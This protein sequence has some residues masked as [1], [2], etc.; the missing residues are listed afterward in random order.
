[1]K[2]ALFLPLI[3]KLSKVYFSN[4]LNKEIEYKKIFFYTLKDLG[5]VYIKFLQ[6]ICLA[7]DFMSDWAGPLE[8][9]VFNKVPTEDMNILDYVK[10][11]DSFSSIDEIP[12]ACGS[13]AQ[14]Y[15]AQLTTGEVV[16]IKVLRPSIRKNLYSDLNKLSRMVKI[17]SKFLPNTIFDY[18]GAF[19]EF[20]RNCLLEVN[21]E[22]EIANMKYFAKLYNNHSYIEIPRVYDKFSSIDIIVQEYI[23]GPTLADVLYDMKVGDTP[24]SLAYKLTES[25]LW[26]QIMIAGGE[27]LVSAMTSDYVYGDP[28]PGNIILLKND[29]IAFVDFGI[30]A[31]KPLSQEAFYLW[32]KSYYDFLKGE[33]DFDR[34]L[35]TTCMC[36]CPELTNALNK[37]K[38]NGD[39]IKAVSYALDLK[40]EDLFNNDK[41]STLK[42][43][44][45]EQFVVLF[46]KLINSRD[47]FDIK[48]DIRN[49][50]LLK[51]MLV[52]LGSVVSINT[53]EGYTKFSQL[54]EGTMEYA[55][56]YCDK[57]GIKKDFKQISKYS[58]NESYELITNILSTVANSDE[59]LFDRICEKIF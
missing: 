8:Y 35:K 32:I 39:F 20:C 46:N 2:R 28:H 52:F 5:G 43:T 22:R 29:K 56:S 24:F 11:K 30:I 19:E 27:A 45:G 10:N 40:E 55:L 7:K 37:C 38:F 9:D 15:K 25:N 34:L 31:S 48:I 47:A 14:L 12:F 1:M 54:M 51:S 33:K 17:F 21:Y 16:A 58:V 49:F 36:L 42:Y 6:I 57:V 18:K 23:E 50:Q 44:E 4:I 53:E 13:F 59:F 41:E 26:K 3:S